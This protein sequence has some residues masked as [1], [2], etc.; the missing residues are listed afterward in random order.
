METVT[1]LLGYKGQ[2]GS[3]RRASHGWW[4]TRV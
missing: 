2:G 3:V 1:Y 4:W